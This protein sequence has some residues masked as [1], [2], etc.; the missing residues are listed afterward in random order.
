MTHLD[1]AI[2]ALEFWLA[3]EEWEREK[4]LEVI[5]GLPA[6]EAIDLMRRTDAKIAR[7]KAAIEALNE[8]PAVGAAGSSNSIF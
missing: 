2:E 6:R 5:D 8:K 3:H 7:I 1:T 4:T